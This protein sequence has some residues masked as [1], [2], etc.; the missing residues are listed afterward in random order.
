VHC[1]FVR[2]SSVLVRCCANLRMH[3]VGWRERE[4]Q[5]RSLAAPSAV[6]VVVVGAG[7]VQFDDRIVAGE[8]LG[9]ALVRSQ[10]ASLVPR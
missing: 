7:V 6:E 10:N 2:Q 3:Q 1:H 4:K 8:P 5:S 9:G